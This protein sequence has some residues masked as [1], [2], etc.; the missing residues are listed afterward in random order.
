MAA[1]SFLADVPPDG[2][3]CPCQ[4]KYYSFKDKDKM[5]SVGSMFYAI[6]F[7]VSFPMFYRHAPI[8][9]FCLH[10]LL[11][12]GLHFPGGA[13]LMPEHSAVRPIP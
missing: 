6:Y 1:C 12:P 9:S 13:A 2:P 5:Y 10:P 7:F 11:L 3:R 8:S 4:F